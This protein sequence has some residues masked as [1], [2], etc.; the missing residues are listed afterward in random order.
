MKPKNCANR[1]WA[2]I[3]CSRL[4]TPGSQRVCCCVGDC[5]NTEA[6]QGY[7]ERTWLQMQYYGRRMEAVTVCADAVVGANPLSTNCVSSCVP[8]CWRSTAIWYLVSVARL[9]RAPGQQLAHLA[10]LVPAKRHTWP[11]Q[12]TGRENRLHRADKNRAL[13][14]AW[15]NAGMLREKR[16]FPEYAHFVTKGGFQHIV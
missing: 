9:W 7:D 16:P 4:T 13:W 1:I 3:Q 15:H 2:E 14:K 6:L 8:A 12:C 10:P 5:V 11:R